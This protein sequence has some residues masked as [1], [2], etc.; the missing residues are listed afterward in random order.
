MSGDFPH[1]LFQIPHSLQFWSN[2][3][4]ICTCMLVKL[5]VLML[6]VMTCVITL[7]RI[8]LLSEIE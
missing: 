2:N 1:F 5:S 4:P 7:E 3:V 8:P 6:E